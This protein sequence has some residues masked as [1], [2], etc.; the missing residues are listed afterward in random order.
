MAYDMDRLA[1]IRKLQ[2]LKY[3]NK[4][5]YGILYLGNDKKVWFPSQTNSSGVWGDVTQNLVGKAY[6][7]SIPDYMLSELKTFTN[8]SKSY[9]S[10]GQFSP[11][12]FH[13]QNFRD[14]RIFNKIKKVVFAE[15]SEHTVPFDNGLVKMDD[16][17]ITDIFSL[18]LENEELFKI[19]EADFKAIKAAFCPFNY[20]FAKIKSSYMSIE[21]IHDRPN[22]FKWRLKQSAIQKIAGYDRLAGDEKFS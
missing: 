1:V 19:F 22:S 6:Q 5:G 7:G 12:D 16:R 20:K 17:V 13:D 18:D 3:L 10:L 21:A 2:K 14:T 9:I 8:T 15:L 4:Q 11:S